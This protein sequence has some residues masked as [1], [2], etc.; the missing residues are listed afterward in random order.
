MLISPFTVCNN[1]KLVF[2][3]G[4]F[5]RLPEEI[6]FY[7]KSTA[8][9]TGG[10]SL[11]ESG[12]L[13]LLSEK[14]YALG[15]EF[16]IF[17][18][19]SEPSPEI[20]DEI[21]VKIKACSIDSIAAVGG[22][23]VID[24]AKAVSALAC[25]DGSITDFL[26]GIGNKKPS[27][28]KLPVI[29]VPT[30]AGT[31]SEA[32]YNAVITRVGEQGFKKSL[33]HPNY[34]PDSVIIDPEL[35]KGCPASIAASSGLDALSQ[36]I[37][38]YISG[39]SVF[40]IDTLITGAVECILEALPVV[41]MDRNDDDFCDSDCTAAWEKM[42]YGAYISGIA[43]A[44]SGLAVIH[45]IGGPIG[46]FFDIP[47]GVI[48]G[49]LLAPG[50]KATNEKLEKE[51]PDSPA[52][53]KLA[54]LGYIAAKSED[55]LPREAR[56]RLIQI[57]ESMTESLGIRRLSHYGISGADLEKIA[58][59]SSNKNNPVLFSTEEMEAIIESRL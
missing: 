3:T 54:K 21:A 1:R 51:E 17:S 16:E 49:N 12:K 30:T 22:G 32:T 27:G 58:A 40:M 23:S 59:A 31:G 7:G 34:I 41:T 5:E 56:A 20:I 45:G 11:K 26:E 48:C 25:E 9:F 24:V 39:K 33:R 10:K 6:E 15:V 14:L 52:L 29:A 13:K 35:Y 50:L 28:R 19:N 38:A 37:E 43:L 42:A 57:I 4:A 55:M 36:L 44:N 53:I 8:I 2:E 18:I 47:H 46:G